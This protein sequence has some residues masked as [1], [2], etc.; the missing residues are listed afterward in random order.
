MICQFCKCEMPDRYKKFNGRQMAYDVCEECESAKR[1]EALKMPQNPGSRA[2][3]L[4]KR[5]TEG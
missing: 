5:K 1:E 2:R 3:D 4:A